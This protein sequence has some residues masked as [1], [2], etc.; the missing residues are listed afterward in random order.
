[1]PRSFQ[2]VSCV[3][4]PPDTVKSLSIASVSHSMALTL[5]TGSGNSLANL[6]ASAIAVMPSSTE[7]N[8]VVVSQSACSKWARRSSGAIRPSCRSS[9]HFGKRSSGGSKNTP[10][11]RSAIRPTRS[12]GCIS[13][14]F[15]HRACALWFFAKSSGVI[16]S[17][18]GPG[19]RPL[20]S[21]DNA[22]QLLSKCL[23]SVTTPDRGITSHLLSTYRELTSPYES[24]LPMLHS[25]SY[26]PCR[27]RIKS[28]ASR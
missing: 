2:T 13:T 28:A 25:A 5:A 3:S 4:S 11:R 16:V 21:I 23:A 27:S 24:V 1:M 9:R 15:I 20:V 14:C 26:L 19:V 22:A 8:L 12:P 10:R 18:V 6:T 7:L 17:G